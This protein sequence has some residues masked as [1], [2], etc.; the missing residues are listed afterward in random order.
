MDSTALLDPRKVV[1]GFLVTPAIA[2]IA[3]MATAFVVTKEH[4]GECLYGWIVAL[5]IF[6]GFAASYVSAL[7]IAVPWFLIMYRIGRL[8]FW[9]TMIGAMVPW[10]GL[11]VV[12]FIVGW[13]RGG[14]RDSMV[15]LGVLAV[16]YVPGMLLA[17]AA[18]YGMAIRSRLSS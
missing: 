17:G 8:G 12:L 16:L 7:V 9:T 15:I 18:F 2:P 10:A 11:F 4:R 3:A 1:L 6:I 14:E 13:C 5:T